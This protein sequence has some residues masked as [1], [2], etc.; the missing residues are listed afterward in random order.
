MKAYASVSTALGL[1]LGLVSPNQIYGKAD[2]LVVEVMMDQQAAPQRE[3]V[4][5]L[6]REPTSGVHPRGKVKPI[7][8]AQAPTS[9]SLAD[10]ARVR[11]FMSGQNM[12]DYCGDTKIVEG[13]ESGQYHRRK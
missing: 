1:A 13:D 4:D 11:A 9:P 2:C 7:K 3:P 5:P 6:E 8:N 10:Q 12:A